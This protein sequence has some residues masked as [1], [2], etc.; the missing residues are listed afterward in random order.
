MIYSDSLLHFLSSD[1]PS[2]T[3]R[4]Q[5]R[6]LLC[7]QTE[8]FILNGGKIVQEPIRA[9]VY[10]RKKTAAQVRENLSEEAWARRQW[11][12]GNVI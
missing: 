2:V 7:K 9:G 12:K 11:M 10:E 4:E 5:D 3:S 8:D 6:Q 1:L